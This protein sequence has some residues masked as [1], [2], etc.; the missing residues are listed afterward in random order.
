MFDKVLIANRGEIAVRVARSLKEMG[1]SPVAVFSEADRRALHVRVC[2]EAWCVGPAPSNES[3][4]VMERIIEAAHKA[5]AQA[6]HPGYGFLSENAR[7]AQAVADAGLTWIGPPP[8]AIVAMG[9]KT[10]A[11]KTMQEAGVP[12]VP[13]SAAIADPDEA[14]AFARHAGFPVLVKAAAGGG[15][16]GMRR[17]DRE[18]DFLA[19]FQGARREAAAAFGDDTVYIEKYVVRPKHVEFQLLSDQHGHHL[20]VF[21]R[22]CSIQRRHQK[23]IEETPCPLL[24]DDVR[25]AMGLVATR[26][27]EAVGYVGAG[28]VEF[29]L[30]VDQNFYFLEMNTR[31]QV[32]HPVT[33]LVTGL[34]LVKWQV[35]IAAGQP[36]PFTQQDL[37]QRGHSIQCRIY[38]EEP[39]NN[40]MPSPGTIDHLAVPAGAGVRDDS[41]VYSGATVP[42]FYDP[43]I[44]KL[45]VWAETREAAID[46]MHRAL[47]EYVIR[48]IETNIEFHR[49]LL[50]HPA[51]VEGTYDTQFVSDHLHELISRLEDRTTATDHEI[52]L[53]AAA[54]FAFENAPDVTSATATTNGHAG[55]PWKLQGR[56]KQLQRL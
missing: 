1:I 51:F 10:L 49:V 28:T 48:G 32:E 35:R 25:Q 6:I 55:D 52:A 40:F 18:A 39:R 11:R 14:L 33:E 8:E 42:M 30:D 12:V 9:S 19:A 38:A 31:L 3:Y 56:Y 43:M 7:F 41:G 34:D 16:K 46:K 15:G 13:G 44:S 53:L 24:R 22:D 36:I 23:V 26:A 4:L 27:V 17:V 47:G 45:C 37:A 2:D 50:D 54:I 5:G 29:L 20:H 21:E